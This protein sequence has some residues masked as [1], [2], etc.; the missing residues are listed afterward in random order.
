MKGNICGTRGWSSPK[1]AHE[2]HA[3]SPLQLRRGQDYHPRRAS[4]GRHLPLHGLPP[5]GWRSLCRHS[6]LARWGRDHR[7]RDGRQLD[8]SDDGRASLL[9]RSAC[10]PIRSTCQSRIRSIRS[11]L[12]TSASMSMLPTPE[13][14]QAAFA[15]KMQQADT[16]EQVY[17]VP[18]GSLTKVQAV[19]AECRRLQAVPHPP[20]VEC[21]V[22]PMMFQTSIAA[23][24]SD[25]SL[26]R[27]TLPSRQQGPVQDDTGRVTHSLH[28]MPRRMRSPGS[29]R[30]SVAAVRPMDCGRT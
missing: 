13:G 4:Q 7:G 14:R 8:G 11:W 3:L 27:P 10:H 18:F 20:H 15:A 2:W 17:V 21:L 25:S 16:L 26:Y 9:A 29:R 30:A 5:G 28:E 6:H 1:V 23:A 24:H 19:R 12:P 22:L